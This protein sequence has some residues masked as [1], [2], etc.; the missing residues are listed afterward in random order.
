MGGFSTFTAA[1]EISQ[2]RYHS[3]TLTASSSALSNNPISVCSV[4]I[5]SAGSCY[6]CLDSTKANVFSV[7][8]KDRNTA[9]LNLGFVP[10]IGKL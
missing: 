6:T 9:T 2:S 10:N 8:A 1:L 7:V 5:Q 3:I 4:H